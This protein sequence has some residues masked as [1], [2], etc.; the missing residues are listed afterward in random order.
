MSLVT[1]ALT[2]LL[3]TSDAA[4]T[5]STRDS[6]DKPGIVRG[7]VTSA[8]TGKPLRRARVRLLPVGDMRGGSQ[9]TANTN[10]SGRF[11]IKNV[12]PGSYYLAGERAGFVRTEYGQRNALERGLTVD[13]ASAQELDRM[14]LALPVGGVLAGRITDELGEPYQGVSVTLITF[15]YDSGKRVPLPSGGATTD[16][17]GR[18]RIA[19]LAPGHYNLV[20]M[21]NETWRDQHKQTWGYG[22]TYY[23]G[24]TPDSARTITLATSE[25]RTNL[26]F[27]LY[28]GRTVRIAGRAQRE[29]GDPIAGGQ[30]SLLYSFQRFVMMAGRRSVRTGG[31]GSF[32][33][34]DVPPGVYNVGGGGMDRTITVTGADIDDLVLVG[35]TGSTVHG[36]V[37][38]DEGVP[39]P[40][41]TSGV[42]VLLQTASDDVLPTVRVVQ[43]EADW[44]FRLQS[45][46]G[47]FLFR[48][49]GL[50]DEWTLAAV[51]LED[52]DITDV[53]YD[54]PTGGKEIRG[55]H[56]LLTRQ[57]GRVAGTVTDGSGKPVSH[58]TVVV[59]SEEAE[60]WRPYSRHVQATRPSADGKFQIKGLPPGTYRAIVRDFI[61][62]GQ[63][64]DRQ[65]LESVRDEGVRFVLS[66]GGAQMLTLR[67]EPQR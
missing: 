26:E 18:F 23:P 41:P 33:F 54:V 56:V 25:Q 57:I 49:V 16:D 22:M 30:I 66:E 60:H 14:D 31:D 53:E 40:F 29:N 8:A 36:S 64:E 58:A 61:E 39:P 4:Q 63:W 2:L 42:R 44:S 12:P 35:R 24:G 34:H 28:A 50:P 59:F 13:V 67:L 17:A 32:V 65:F 43:V 7:S 11:E 55:L 52:K 21:S 51:R 3:V 62:Q 38:T 48:V 47:P 37:S 20:A 19:G 10:S 6:A 46:G 5:P 9:L 27:S 45:V 1:A 15:R